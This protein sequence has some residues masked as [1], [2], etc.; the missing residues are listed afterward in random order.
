MTT[1]R[2]RRLVL[3]RHG[4]TEGQSSIR[5]FGRT[6]V[7]LSVV[8]RAQMER[9]RTALQDEVFDAVY[10]SA[11]QR[12]VAAAQIIVP[13]LS[14]QLVPGFNEV[15]FGEWEGLTREEIAARNPEASRRWH[16]SLHDFVYPGGESVPAFRARVVRALH[17]LLREAPAYTLIVAHRGVISSIV[18]DLLHLQ[19]AERAAWG[20]DLACLHVLVATDGEW[21]PERVNDNRHLHGLA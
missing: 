10:T 9:V 3:V 1:Q 8:G 12:A 5:Y 13:A 19:P 15:D 17:T 18:A 4:E 2:V 11:L 21:R 7:P 6:D 16:A 20:L 14:P